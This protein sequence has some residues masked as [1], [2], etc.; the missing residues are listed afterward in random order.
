MRNRQSGFTLIELVVVITILGILAAFAIPRFTQ[1]DGQARIAAVNA[2]AGSLQSASALAHAQYLASGT[3]PAIVA[4][5]GQDIT[6]DQRLSR[7]DGER[8]PKC[9]AGH[10]RIYRDGCRNRGHVHEE[11]C[12][13]AH[14]L[15]GHLYRVGCARFARRRSRC[16]SQPRLLSADRRRRAP[17]GSR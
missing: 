4:M 9:A 1:L 17:I 16:Q 15:C 11:R 3:A 13:D 2:L 6:L 14:D 8:H 12:A 7:P 10:E 5:D